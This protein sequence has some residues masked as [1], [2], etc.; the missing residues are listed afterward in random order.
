MVSKKNTHSDLKCL[1]NR[2]SVGG[3]VVFRFTN[4]ISQQIECRCKTPDVFYRQALKKFAEMLS[5][6][7]L[8][9]KKLF[10]KI[11]LVFINLSFVLITHGIYIS[12]INM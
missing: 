5:N 4:I 7:I 10:G 3:L 11:E 9:T 8:F 1:L 2:L 6:A 12:Y